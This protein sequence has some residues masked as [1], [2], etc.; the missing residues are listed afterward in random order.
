ME[1]AVI[2]LIALAVYLAWDRQRHPMKRCRACRTSPGK[3][4]SKWNG[5]AY[6][7]CRRCAGAG[8]VRR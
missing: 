4:I 6:G 8:E 5:Q 3:K 7:V 2:L 1:L